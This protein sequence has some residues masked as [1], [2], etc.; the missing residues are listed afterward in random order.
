MK[1]E[2]VS[3]TLKAHIVV[4]S[5]EFGTVSEDESLKLAWFEASI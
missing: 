5:L 4:F 3:I 2:K 1:L